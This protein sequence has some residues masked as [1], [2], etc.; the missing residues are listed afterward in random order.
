M[1]GGCL[2][3]AIPAM[4]QKGEHAVGAA[5]MSRSGDDE[6]GLSTAQ[7]SFHFRNPTQMPWIVKTTSAPFYS[8]VHSHG[9]IVARN[10]RKARN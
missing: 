2:F 6:V 4:T 3:D 8:C 10:K 1:T 5:H 7:V 9:L